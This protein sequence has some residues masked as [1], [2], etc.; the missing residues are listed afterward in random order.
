[1]E[2]PAAAGAVG[3]GWVAGLRLVPPG[4]L[5]VAG[6][7]GL[8]GAGLVLSAAYLTLARGGV[9]WVPVVA[10]A[11]AGPVA[12]YVALHLLRGTHWAWLAVVL[13]T[14]LL[15]ASSLW[16]LVAAPPP[17]VAPLG[18][19]AVELLALGYLLR[20]RVRAAFRAR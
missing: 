19:I 12:I 4:V 10:G 16:R 7:L 14:V 15:L 13:V 8:L 5:V 18:E 6:V 20:P 9:G 2:A 3:A 1:V 11:G 17:P